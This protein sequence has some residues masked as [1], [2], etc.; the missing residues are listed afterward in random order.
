VNL[1]LWKYIAIGVALG[2]AVV[3]FAAAAIVAC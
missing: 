1:S 3:A 2:G